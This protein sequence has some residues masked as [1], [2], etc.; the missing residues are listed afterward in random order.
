MRNIR[1]GPPFGGE[2]L[3]KKIGYAT[4]LDYFVAISSVISIVIVVVMKLQ[5]LIRP[6]TAVPSAF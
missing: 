5:L 4:L 1:W 3:A 2:R 6:L